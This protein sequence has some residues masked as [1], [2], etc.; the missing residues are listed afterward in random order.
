M[1]Q[2]IKR[3][4]DAANRAGLVRFTRN[5]YGGPIIVVTDPKTGQREIVDLASLMVCGGV[6]CA[7][8]LLGGVLAGIEWGLVG[9]FLFVVPPIATFAL[10][11]LLSIRLKG[12]AKR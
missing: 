5:T 6:A 8:L 1:W 12:R 4:I 10:Y 2:R 9:A 3:A 11:I 7:C